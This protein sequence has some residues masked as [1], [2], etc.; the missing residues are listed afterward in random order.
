[1]SEV[2]GGAD[3]PARQWTAVDRRRAALAGLVSVALL[4]LLWFQAFGGGDE[5]DGDDRAGAW[6]ASDE[7]LEDVPG[8][9]LVTYQESVTQCPGLPW[10][11][12]AAV[13]KA[14]TDHNRAPGTSSAGAVGPM[15][16]LP[17]TWRQFQADGD[18]D[19]VADI[20]DE[21]DAIAGAVRLLCAGGG[22]DPAQLRAA[23]FTYNR[24]DE[25]VEDVLAIAR[26]Y[27]TATIDA[28]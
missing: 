17:A 18:G 23:L 3:T 7:A 22:D 24:S 4:G 6:P 1:M 25:Y 15:Q 11:V 12:V 13:G 20:E 2:N 9:L 21:E 10:P 19:G 8:D 28:P 26:S 27:T 5:D 16:F 14:E